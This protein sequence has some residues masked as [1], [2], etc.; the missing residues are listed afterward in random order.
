MKQHPPVPGLAPGRGYSHVV[1]ATGGTLI[2]I[3]GQVS[4]NAVG[5]IVGPGDLEAQARQTYPNLSLALK[6]AGATFADLVKLNVYVVN[7]DADAV[8]TVRKV[9]REFLPQDNPPASTLV[10][11]TAL[12]A[13]ELLIEVEA[14]A[15]ID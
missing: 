5:E 11:V 9:R 6:A 13:A 15:H 4:I 10:G 1:T 3:A 2:Y 12:A 8:S 7:L 14:V